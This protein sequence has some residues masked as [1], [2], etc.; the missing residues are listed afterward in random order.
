MHYCFKAS[1]SEKE[2]EIGQ[3]KGIA[4]RKASTVETHEA[5]ATSYLSIG[6]LQQY[7]ELM[8]RLHQWDHALAI[9]PAV[10]IDYWRQLLER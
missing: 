9:A 3:P 8:I 10:S 1:A 7:C 6:A 5:L 4:N 2:L